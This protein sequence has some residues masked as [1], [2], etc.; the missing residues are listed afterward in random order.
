[1]KLC[2][3]Y[4]YYGPAMCSVSTISGLAVQWVNFSWFLLTPQALLSAAEPDDP[5]DAVVAQQVTDEHNILLFTP[6]LYM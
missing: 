1:M 4:N 2:S 3:G 6:Y 5:Q